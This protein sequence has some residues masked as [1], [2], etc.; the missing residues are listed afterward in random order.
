MHLSSV[1]H[2]IDERRKIG[3]LESTSNRHEERIVRAAIEES[4]A[5]QSISSRPFLDANALAAVK[6]LI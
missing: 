5:R 2:S 4:D 3:E 1:V 6:L